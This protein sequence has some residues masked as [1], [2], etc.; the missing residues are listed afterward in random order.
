MPDGG[1]PG[2][3]AGGS[4][5]RRPVRAGRDR[6]RRGRRTT[7]VS[8]HRLGWVTARDDDALI[9]FVNVAWEGVIHA[10]VLDPL[11]TATARRQ[12]VGRRLVATAVDGARAA[13]CA[14][15]HVDFDDHLEQF[16][17][18]GCGFRPTRAGLIAR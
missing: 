12:G 1:R 3:V 2:P 7:Q 13:G 14:W 10:F 18:D 16:Y 5:S 17:F 15:L 4:T 8:G 11:V 6:G 9:G